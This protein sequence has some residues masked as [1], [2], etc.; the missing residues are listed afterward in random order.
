MK[1]A[2]VI[3]TI[4]YPSKALK[5]FAKLKEF[6]MFVAGDNK[7]PSGWKLDKVHYFSIE[8]QQKKYPVLSEL[9]S[10]NHYARKNFGYLEAIKTGID[11]LYE[12]DDDNLPYD[13]FP[14]FMHKTVK[15]ESLACDLA[16]NVY[17]EFTNEPIWP[18]GLP[19]KNILNNN[20]RKTKKNVDPLIQ[21]SLADLDPDVDA[22]Y[23]L[24]NGKLVTFK[25]NR[26]VSISKGTYCPF[27]SQNTYW[28]QSV[29]PLLYLPS[30]VESRVTDIW[31]GYIAQRILWELNSEVV[32]SSASV[33][34]ERNV[35][36]Y[37]KDFVQELE[38]YTRVDSLLASLTEVKLKGSVADM[39]HQIYLKLVEESYFDEREVRAVEEWLIQLQAD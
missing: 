5:K 6:D 20:V 34:Q 16:Y 8:N 9:T 32:F 28:H 18:R 13:I 21:Q 39:L 33:F 7:T 3:T 2:I 25:K 19:L 1:K 4:N 15:I 36:D 10:Q 27:N 11:Y 31:R 38:L 37:L 22:I 17:S 35:H 23:R 29:F 14:T 24:T 26:K 12:T 30:T